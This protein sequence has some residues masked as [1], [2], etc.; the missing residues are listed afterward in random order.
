MIVVCIVDGGVLVFVVINCIDL[1]MVCL[2]VGV[3]ILLLVYWVLGLGLKSI[4]C[5]VVVIIV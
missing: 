4:K 1:F 3:I 5:L 2:G